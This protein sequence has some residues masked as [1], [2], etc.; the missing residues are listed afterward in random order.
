[1]SE[2]TVMFVGAGEYQMPGILRALDLGHRVVAVDGRAE[3]PGLSVAHAAAVVD[4][5]DADAC[6][7][8][9]VHEAIDGVLTIASDAAV[10]SVAH[11]AEAMGLPGISGVVAERVTDK[12]LMRDAFSAA[13]ILQPTSRVVRSCVEARRTAAEIGYPVV[14]KPANSAGSRGVSL[15]SVE[16]EVSA[17]YA[18][19]QSHS[20]DRKVLMEE[21][22]DGP[23]SSVEGYVVDGVLKVLALSDK[24]RTEPP[25]MLD[26][27][28]V[29][30]SEFTD[31]ER[32]RVEHTAQAC[33][34]AVGLQRGPIHLEYIRSTTGP[35]PI[36]I[37]ARGPGFKVFSEII[38]FVSGV[39]VV[40]AV[41]RDALGL[42]VDVS[43][44][45][46]NAAAIGFLESPGDGL[47]EAIHGVDVARSM[48]GVAEL[49]LYVRPGDR[50]RRLESGA[51]RIG[52]VIAQSD[53]RDSVVR[54][55]R[56]ATESITVVLQ[57]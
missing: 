47:L 5:R 25:H 10:R 41:I 26:R 1:M 18:S 57:R 34:T 6:L 42:P 46:D 33:V 15:V 49:E 37:A 3:A 29:F 53:Q 24:T 38:P 21:F 45:A 52:H 19:A 44:A 54:V 51:D 30:P 7:A 11:V 4:V 9:A 27:L 20:S 2:S 14:V 40:L 23:E 28:V 8:V 50:L 32:A 55:V 36:E 17:A 43:V 39:D 16:A 13:G 12:A 31:Q 56:E 48:P 22:V 35:V